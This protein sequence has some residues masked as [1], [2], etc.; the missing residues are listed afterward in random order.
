MS[1]DVRWNFIRS[2]VENKH[3]LEVGPAELVGTINRHKLDRWIHHKIAKVAKRL[4]GLE[5]NQMIIVSY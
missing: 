3:V 1:Y 2:Y 5:K 4:I